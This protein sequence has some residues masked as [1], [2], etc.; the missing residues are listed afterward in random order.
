MPE[1]E[2]SWLDRSTQF[3]QE[4]FE[5]I[6]YFFLIILFTWLYVEILFLAFFNHWTMSQKSMPA[7]QKLQPKSTHSKTLSSL[8]VLYYHLVLLQ[9]I[10]QVW[11]VSCCVRYLL[12][13]ACTHCWSWAA[14]HKKNKLAKLN[15]LATM[16]SYQKVSKL[17]QQTFF[18]QWFCHP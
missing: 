14:Q 1:L 12:V 8:L 2:L 9:H 18:G 11:T 6:F 16:Q 13:T 7:I 10:Q 3:F 15:L 5:K 4:T 17:T